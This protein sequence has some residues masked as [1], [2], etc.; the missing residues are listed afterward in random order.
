MLGIMFYLAGIPVWSLVEFL[1]HRYIYHGRFLD[2]RLDALHR[3]QHHERPFE[4]WHLSGQLR[5]FLPPF[6]VAAR[7]SFL[8]PQYPR[9]VRRP[10]SKSGGNTI[11]VRKMTRSEASRLFRERFKQP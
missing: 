6:F 7:L 11:R 9:L 4:G 10:L 3:E 8:F 5:D 2:G 1:F